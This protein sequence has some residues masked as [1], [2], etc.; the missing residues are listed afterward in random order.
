VNRRGG[1]VERGVSVNDF[2]ARLA[3][4]VALAALS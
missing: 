3:A 4:D 2:E 1:D